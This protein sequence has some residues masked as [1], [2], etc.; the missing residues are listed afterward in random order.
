MNNWILRTGFLAVAGAFSC[1]A[2]AA[3]Y[4][5]SD[6]QSGAAAGC[7]AGNGANAGT[8]A[9]SPKQTFSQVPALRAGDQVL[10]AKGGAWT[11]AGINNAGASST[12]ASPII[13]DSYTPSWGG[14]AKP[15]LSETRADT[16]GFF[17]QSG[18]GMIIRNL[19]LRGGGNASGVFVYSG[20]NNTTL[21]S[22]TITG[23]NGAFY[24]AK[25]PSS[26]AFI[27]VKNSSLRNSKA[28]GILSGCDDMLF[29]NNALD[30]N[31][32]TAIF[33]HN[34]YLDNK[35]LRNV[36]RGNTL[37]RSTFINGQCQG[38]S[39]VVHGIYDGLTIENNTIIET[40]A[41]NT[42]YGI[43]VAP[44]YGNQEEGFKNVTIRGNRV[45]NVG[46]LGIAASSCQ[47]CTIENNVV[48]QQRTQQFL[49]IGVSDDSRDTYDW[50][51]SNIVVRNNSIYLTNSSGSDS[52]GVQ[53]YSNGTNHTVVSNLVYLN[54]GTG[55]IC[56]GTGGR[57]VSG[58]TAFNSNLCYRA[59]GSGL[60]STM[61]SVL[62]LAQAAGLDLGG[63]SA[64]PNLLATPSASNNW[65]MALSSTSPAI[66]AGNATLSA[67]TDILGSARS[68]PD[69]GAF[70]FGGAVDKTPPSPPSSV[71]IQ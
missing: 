29:E 24:C 55:S 68:T 56:F 34:I 64:N 70:E 39:L 46:G 67:K 25:G 60:Y 26:P 38:V 54:S 3:V 12:T 19:E 71:A 62:S 65:S 53:V 66:N 33:D 13:F 23:F 57:T 17:I 4:Y 27:T 58:F 59:S 1:A 9:S 43:Q 32:Q 45:I 30:N 11:N 28:M 6:C 20:G 42:C 18:Q 15:I 5:V 51:N 7:V 35:G 41:A 21:D 40:A 8:S 16:N 37:T 49:G 10:F 44:G 50:T 69:M 31:G 14:T 61:Y 2:S 22:L 48:V 36:I 47:T 63:T 52:L